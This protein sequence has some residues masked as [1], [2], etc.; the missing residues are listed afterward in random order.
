MNDNV[1]SEPIEINAGRV[2]D[3]ISRIG[4][5]SHAAIMDI[6]DNSIA[7]QATKVTIH[8]DRKTGMRIQ[9]KNN[10]EIYR[11]IDNGK[12][13]LDVDIKNAL[14]LGSEDNYGTHSLSKYGLG[15]K[16]A[17]F[18]LGTKIQIVSKKNDEFSKLFYVDRNEIEEDYLIFSR[19]LSEAEEVFYSD[20]INDK[21]GTVIDITSSSRNN[22][23]SLK[24]TKEKLNEKLGVVYYEFL[25]TKD[26]SIYIEEKDQ[27][28][29]EIQPFDILFLEDAIKGGY[30]KGTHDFTK[31]IIVY[32]E[33][34]SLIPITESNPNPIKGKLQ[35][36][37]FPRAQMAQS[38]ELTKEE[39]K[40]IASYKIGIE[41][42][43]FFIYRNNR[44]IK[45]GDSLDIVK[46]KDL[47]FR[48]KL[49]I[50]SEHDEILH[51]DVS[52]QH[53]NVPEKIIDQLEGIASKPLEYA[54]LL[55]KECS[56]KLQSAKEGSKSNENM[57]N[58]EMDEEEVLVIEESPS[59]EEQE[60]RR[61]KLIAETQELNKKINTS[62]TEADTDKKENLS[63]ENKVFNFIRYSTVVDA[64]YLWQ[65][66]YDEDNGDFVV[67]NQNHPY[68]RDIL[69]K[70]DNTKERQAIEILL[71]SLAFG[72]RKALEKV[73]LP[74]SD[75]KKVLEKLKLSF[76]IS[77][78]QL[79]SHIRK[80]F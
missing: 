34:L 41:N 58:F 61:K 22:N 55:M 45:W 24:Q 37:I 32:D 20:L 60:L 36:C 64:E 13:M 59:K 1:I 63:V 74:D 78:T 29:I 2:I 7:A 73:K 18:S 5:L 12:G 80:D 52:K 51:V 30:Q 53:L 79:S 68:Y 42:K 71:F 16:S 33:E 25:K 31:P 10:V 47:N 65:T 48:A 43:G 69:S 4:Y 19:K 77:V 35:I 70:L 17:G 23:Q 14:Q 54:N 15:L 40:K 8:F 66:G 28:R 44:L 56:L 50:Y 49:F 38:L 67:I 76:S 26:L 27:E 57:Q 6:V 39:R 21:S 75:I 11:I 3:A 46:R 9:Q 62:D 72:E